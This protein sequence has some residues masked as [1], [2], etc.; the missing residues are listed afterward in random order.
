M[1]YRRLVLFKILAMEQVMV[2]MKKDQ[3]PGENQRKGNNGGVKVS[4]R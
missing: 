4:R 1:A 3:I 2:M